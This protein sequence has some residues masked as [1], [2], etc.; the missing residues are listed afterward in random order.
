MQSLAQNHGFVDGNKRT[1]VYMMELLLERSGYVLRGRTEE[2]LKADIEAM[3]L[4]VADDDHARRME[5]DALVRWFSA[6]IRKT[7]R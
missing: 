5:F 2:I 7:R 3:I 1:T 6:R 4:A